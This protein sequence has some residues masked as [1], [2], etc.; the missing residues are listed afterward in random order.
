MLAKV[1]KK[2]HVNLVDDELGVDERSPAK[3][4]RQ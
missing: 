3:E 1:G 4:V 2:S